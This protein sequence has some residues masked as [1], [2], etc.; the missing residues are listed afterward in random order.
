MND[1]KNPDNAGPSEMDLFRAA[2]AGV[3]PIAQ[4]NRYI[5][6]GA[7]PRPLPLQSLRD[8][9]EV[10]ADSLSDYIPYDIEHDINTS[11][12]R[13]GLP[14]TTLRKLQ[15]RN[16]SVQAHL[17]LHGLTSDEARQQLV[18]FLDNCRKRHCRCV[19]IIHGKGLRSKNREPVLKHKVRSW[20]MQRDE[21]L[22][23]CEARPVDGGSGA[24]M[25]LLK[26]QR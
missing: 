19:R 17:D 24:V 13:N 7:R 16:W 18:E 11:F 4:N 12:L 23:Y 15:A 3:K 1:E 20:L 2:I 14:K 8:Q 10:L 22:A 26:V 5:F 6:R 9:R 21:I 25:V